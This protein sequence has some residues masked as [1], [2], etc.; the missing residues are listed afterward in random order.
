MINTISF[1]YFP[2]ACHEASKLDDCY[3][4]ESILAPSLDSQTTFGSICKKDYCRIYF[5]SLPVR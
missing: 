4:L 3:N 2:I 1:R 5:A